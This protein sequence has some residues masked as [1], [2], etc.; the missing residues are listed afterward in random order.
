MG[1]FKKKVK[2]QV[3][4]KLPKGII[5]VERGYQCKGLRTVHSTIEQA[6]KQLDGLSKG[7]NEC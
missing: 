5:K 1:L 4:T 7:E 3:K 6:L 2:P